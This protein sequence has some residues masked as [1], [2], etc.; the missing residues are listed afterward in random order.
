MKKIFLKNNQGFTIIEMLVATTLFLIVISI[1]TSIFM[2]NIRTQ[3]YLLASVNASEE[4]S[5]ALEKVWGR[6]AVTPK[7][8][9]GVYSSEYSNE[10]KEIFDKV[11]QMTDEFAKREGRR[12]RILIAKMGQDGHDR[13][14]KVV[15]TAYADMGFDVDVGSSKT[16]LPLAEMAGVIASARI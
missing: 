4:I 6:Y 1:T 9:S 3:R 7:T 2:I 15:A 11:R 12:P 10:D 8:I 16:L 13:G 14:A 5:Y